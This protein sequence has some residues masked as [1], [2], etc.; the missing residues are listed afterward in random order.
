[1]YFVIQKKHN[2]ATDAWDNNVHTKATEDEAFHQF[3]AFMST[4]AYILQR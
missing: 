3:C 4:Y 2:S 1:M